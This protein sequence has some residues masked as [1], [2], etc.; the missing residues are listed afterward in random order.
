MNNVVKL[1]CEYFAAWDKFVDESP[2]GDI[3]C[4]SWWLDAI[5]NSHFEILAIIENGNIVAGMPLAYDRQNKINEPPFTRTLGL[6]FRH[7]QELNQRRRASIERK[8]SNS[9]LEKIDIKNL[10]Q[11]CT[12]HNF[13]DWLPFKWKG[14]SQTTRYTYLIDYQEKN[15]TEIQ[16]ALSRGKK[17]A[18]NKALR[19]G[20]KVQESDEFD[21]FYKY[22]DLTY[23]R[24]G[25][26]MNTSYSVFKT[27]D[28]SIKKNG[29]RLILKAVDQKNNI[30]SISYFAYNKNSAYYLISGK[31]HEFSESAGLTL[32]LWESIIYFSTRVQYFNFGG[33]DIQRIEKYLRGFGGTITPYFHI[34]NARLLHEYDIKYSLNQAS[35]HLI[36]SFKAVLTKM[37]VPKGRWFL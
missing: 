16:K 9:L 31:N 21:L 23:R 3:F 26:R 30:H 7:N 27:L 2:Q 11:L 5:T 14:L 12:H 6:L 22:S 34:Y 19:S 32:I 24:Q 15:F 36:N 28:D 1:G 35:F 20:L 17:S 4:Y 25:K 18:I 33:S 8:W 10:R 37:F 13:Y 29:H